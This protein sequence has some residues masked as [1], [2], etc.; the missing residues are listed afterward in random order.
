M[1]KLSKETTAYKNKLKYISEYNKTRPKV[2]IQLNPKTEQDMI[3]WLADKAK[4]TYI[5]ELIRKDMNKCDC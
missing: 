2:Y 1:S 5:K 3:D 4:A